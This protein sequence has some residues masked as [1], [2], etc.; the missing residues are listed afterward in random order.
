MQ[1]SLFPGRFFVLLIEPFNDLGRLQDALKICLLELHIRPNEDVF[2]TS[3][4]DVLKTLVG[5]A[6]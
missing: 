6:A 2:I 4:G 3:L 5:D 1:K